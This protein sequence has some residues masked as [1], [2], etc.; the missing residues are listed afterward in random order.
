M[1]RVFRVRSLL[2]SLVPSLAAYPSASETR[3]ILREKPLLLRGFNESSIFNFW[4]VVHLRGSRPSS[5]NVSKRYSTREILNNIFLRNGWQS[6]GV[7]DKYL[8][9]GSFVKPAAID[10]RLRLLLEPLVG[11]MTGF[12]ISSTRSSLIVQRIRWYLVASV[13]INCWRTF[14]EDASWCL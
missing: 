1:A 11:S 2:P 4:L 12:L 6:G 9:I 8:P 13:R 10:T 5:S 14:E 7:D 3:S